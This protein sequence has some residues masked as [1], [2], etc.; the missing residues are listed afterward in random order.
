MNKEDIKYQW[1]ACAEVLKP[2]NDISQWQSNFGP[3]ITERSS[4]GR[5]KKVLFQLLTENRANEVY[6]TG[7]FNEWEKDIEKLKNYKLE[8]DKDGVFTK[9]EL[10]GVTHKDQ[11]KFLVVNGNETTLLQDPAGVYFDDNGNTIFWDYKDPSTYKQQH[12]FIDTRLRSTKIVQTDLP[13]LIVHWANKEGVLGQNIT[14]NKYYKFIAESGVIEHI[15]ELGFNTIQFLPFAQSIDGDNW[16]HSYLVPFQF[17]IQKNWGTPDDFAEMIDM[18]HKN[19]IAVIGDFVIGHMPHKDYNI[20]GLG[21][22]DNGIHVW[23]KEDG[24]GLYLDEETSWGTK[25]PCIYNENVR[26]FLVSSVLHFMKHYA[27]DGVR[28]DNVD[29]ILRFGKNGDGDERPHGRYFLQELNKTIY[30][31]NPRALIHFEA[32]YFYEDNAKLLVVPFEQDNRALSATAY[33]SS[34]LTYHLHTDYMPKSVEDSSVWKFKDIISEKEFGQSNATVADFHNHDAAAGLMSMR[35]TGSY[36]YDTMTCKQPENHFHALGK[37]KVMEA[38]ISF[39]QEGRTLDLL[40]SFLLQTGTFEHD[41]SIHW[42]LTYTEVSRNTLKYKKAVNDIMDDPAFWT[43]Y[44]EGRSFLN[45][46]EENKVMVVERL[47]VHDGKESR[48]VIVINISS[49]RHLTYRVGV[50]TKK[51]YSVVLNSDEFIYAGSGSAS[52]GEILKNQSSTSFELLDR[53][54]ILPVLAPY[55]VVVLKEITE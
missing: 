7:S 13:G 16:K 44:V 36:A 1:Q 34:R 49:W 39:V 43:K 46:D 52:Y 45:L 38:I 35:A 14:K 3:I 55:G 25:R 18:F 37:I 48:Y 22:C 28:V 31:Y 6:L 42:H 20:F 15:K 30:S 51:N 2:E 47:A 24:A 40:Q 5:A 10:E 9:L 54:V 21:S 17:A 19:G 23:K 53:E 50:R 32:H 26:A 12:G 11:Y 8:I 4:D 27:I 29:G 41:S 33:N